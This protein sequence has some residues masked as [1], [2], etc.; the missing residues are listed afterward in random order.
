MVLHF[1]GNEKKYIITDKGNWHVSEDCPDAIKNELKKKI[2]LIAIQQK[3]Q[4]KT[5]KKKG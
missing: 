4:E 1:S 5:A 3:L 2:G